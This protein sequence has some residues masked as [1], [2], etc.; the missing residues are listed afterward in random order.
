M[1]N[2][3]L[4]NQTTF[5]GINSP[6]LSTG[7]ITAIAK[8]QEGLPFPKFLAGGVGGQGGNNYKLFSKA[9]TY[10]NNYWRSQLF[11]IQG[12]FSV[13]SIVLSFSIN[14][15]QNHII[16]PV[17]YMDNGGTMVTGNAIDLSHYLDSPK[18]VTLTP[19]N[20]SYNVHGDNNF[21]L[22]LNFTGTALI[23]ITL[24]IVIEVETEEVG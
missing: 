13:R 21:Y 24:P 1:F 7:I 6:T 5:K 2:Q 11:S 22:Q 14:L 9:S 10:S 16:T 4:Y 12:P 23:A 15:N 19:A 20:F 8:V 17:L 18:S 3:N